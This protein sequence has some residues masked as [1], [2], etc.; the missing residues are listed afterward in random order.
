M[1]HLVTLHLTL[2]LGV[3]SHVRIQIIYQYIKYANPCPLMVLVL[4]RCAEHC[5]W[6]AACFLLLMA[7]LTRSILVLWS[8]QDS[9][10][11]TLYFGYALSS[12]K[13]NI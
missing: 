1:V 12:E 13:E 11:R 2:H 6:I 7:T 4:P 3:C 5:G 9:T 8:F 10:H